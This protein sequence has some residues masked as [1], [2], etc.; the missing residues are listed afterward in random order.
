MPILRYVYVVLLIAFLS[1]NAVGQTGIQHY[2]GIQGMGLAGTGVTL[3]SSAGLF[4]NP[5]AIADITGIQLVASSELRFE[6]SGI[7]QFG[8]AAANTI[9]P[10]GVIGITVQQESVLSLKQLKLSL[11]YAKKLHDHLAIGAQLNVHQLQIDNYGSTTVINAAIGAVGKVND[12]IRFGFSIL[13]PFP[14]TFI[15]GEE[16]PTTLIVGVAYVA[17]EQLEIF[18]ELEKDI[19]F[20]VHTKMAIEYTPISILSFRLGIQT[21]PGTVSFGMGWIF[22]DQLA[23][24]IAIYAHDQLGYSPGLGIRYGL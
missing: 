13:N 19:D 9:E 8:L 2:G 21:N 23:L 16:I 20:P 11:N 4:T 7:K 22:T 24:D 14:I 12:Q 10:I 6:S 1:S 17:S 15:D 18:G 3:K 5:A